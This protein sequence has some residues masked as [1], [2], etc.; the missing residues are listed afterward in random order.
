VRQTPIRLVEYDP[1]WSERY[2][3][4]AARLEDAVGPPLDRV[5]HIGST[6]VPGLA[7]KPIV[8]VL[9]VL[10]D[11]DRLRGPGAPVAA[12]LEKL[13]YRFM[14]DRP[15]LDWVHY[16]REAEDGQLFNLHAFPRCSDRWRDDLVFREYLREHPD[17]REE[18]ECLK[19]DLAAEHRHDITG[20]RNGKGEFVERVV[21]RARAS[22]AVDIGR[23]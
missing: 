23:S 22:D 6:A 13:G 12:R 4:E 16:R 1:A 19:R 2:A 18:Y 15:R 14:H 5:E 3:A 8:D 20:Y 17:V 9:V 21:E 11:L 10:D 7:A